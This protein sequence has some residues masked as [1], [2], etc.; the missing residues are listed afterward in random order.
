MNNNERLIQFFDFQLCGR[1]RARGIDHNLVTP[2]ALNQLMLEFNQLRELNLARQNAG[3]KFEICL[4][5]LEERDDCWVLLVNMVDGEAAH[6]V[7]QKI[8]GTD[9]D[10]E[11]VDLGRERGI[12][13]STHLI[14]YKAGDLAGKHVVLSERCLTLPFSRVVQFLNHLARL[15]AKQFPDEYEKPHPNGAKGKTINTYCSFNYLAHPSDEF[16]Q[17]LETGT[18]SD[19]RIT[20]DADIVRGYDANVHAELY[21]TEIRMKVSRYNVMRSGG[22]WNHL[23]KAI[24]YADSLDAPFVRVQFLDDSGAGHTATVST[25]TGQLWK[26]DKYIKKLKIQEF[27]NSLRTAY[28]LIHEGIRGKMLELLE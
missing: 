23:Q 14:I 24:N 8:G 10:R 27:V 28:P 18:L 25:D 2:R 7:T 11:V 13:S 22:N 20:S 9:E 3:I 16:R 19:I 4:E 15:A 26:A 21:S 1:T 17:E 5:D 12:E 6:P